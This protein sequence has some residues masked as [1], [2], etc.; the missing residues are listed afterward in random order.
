[1]KPA[2]ISE[3]KSGLSLL[4][5]KEL[6]ALCVKLAGFRKENKQLLTYI[7]F[8]AD[9]PAL[10]IKNAKEEIS[11]I[12]AQASSNM[13]L[14]KKTYRKALK[15]V[16]DYIRFSGNKTIEVE[17]LIHF[18]HCMNNT[19]NSIHDYPVTSNMY[20]RQIAK[21]EK[22]LQSLHEDLQYDYSGEVE[23]LKG[24]FRG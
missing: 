13:Y 1:M 16:T 7:L 11:Y 14:A 17:L 12:F 8:E 6:I 15:T 4:S 20:N 24:R 23:R 18:C 2:T 21:I 9:D 19:G 3:I 22:A 10:F 5:Q